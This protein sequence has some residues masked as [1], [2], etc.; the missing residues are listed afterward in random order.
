[1]QENI[2]EPYQ[3]SKISEYELLTKYNPKYINSKIKSAQTHINEMYHLSTSFTTCDDNMGVISVSYPIDN[4][5]IWISETKDN[6]KCF[7]DDS[8]V[9]L[10]MLKQILNSYTQD[11]Q[12]QVVRYMQ[13]NGRIKSHEL[14]RRLQV[15]LYNIK[16]DRPMTKPSETQQ[17]MVV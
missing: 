13:S 6:L 17:V 2:K 7:K 12:Q 9:C 3:Q 10:S 8:V 1:M 4:L 5:V 14:I 15:D 16:H 11:K